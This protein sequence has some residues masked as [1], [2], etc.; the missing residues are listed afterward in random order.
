MP[1]VFRF[2]PA[3]IRAARDEAGLTAEDVAGALE[4][5]WRTILNYENGRTPM[6]AERLG[7]FA[8]LVCK[9]PSD[10]YTRS[11]LSA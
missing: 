7:R 10:F 3:R 1:R 4:C 9:T 11:R 2:D 6:P 5:S 8:S